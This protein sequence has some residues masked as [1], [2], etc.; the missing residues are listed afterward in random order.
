MLGISQQ[1]FSKLPYIILLV[2]LIYI[3]KPNIIFKP[4]GKFREYGIGYDEEDYKKTLYTMH[5]IIII[6]VIIL[7]TIEF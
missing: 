1:V 5:F 7:A 3:I 6:S 4:N 2:L